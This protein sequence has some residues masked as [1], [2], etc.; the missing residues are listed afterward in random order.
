MITPNTAYR[1]VK[2]TQVA[3]GVTIKAG[4][5]FRTDGSS[6]FNNVAETGKTASVYALHNWLEDGRIE[7][8][9]RFLPKTGEIFFYINSRGDVVEQR[10]MASAKSK[11]RHTFGNVFETRT[12]AEDVKEILADL[13]TGIDFDVIPEHGYGYGKD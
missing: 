13:L 4:T 12:Q 7:K 3:H 10:W 8:V 11:V 5:D 1:F 9:G 2:D 6:Q